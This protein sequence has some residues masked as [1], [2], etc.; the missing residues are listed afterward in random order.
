[1]STVRELKGQIHR[2]NE[3]GGIMTAMKNLAFMELR[4][5]ERHLEAQQILVERIRYCAGLCLSHFPAAGLEGRPPHRLCLILGS[6]RGFCGD[7]NQQLILKG[8]A[9]LPSD[10]ACGLV[11]LGHRLNQRDLGGHE[12]LDQLAGASASEEVEP[13][14]IALVHRLGRLEQLRGPF[15]LTVLFHHPEAGE[16]RLGEVLPPFADLEPDPPAGSPPL[17]GLGLPELMLGIGEQFLMAEL[18]RVLYCSLMAE[19]QQRVVHLQGAI[20][21]LEQHVESL[22]R[23]SNH[24]RQEAIIEEIEIILM[25][26]AE[27]LDP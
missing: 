18:Q 19:N 4:K 9:M 17:L 22:N 10:A 11:T 5:L 6:E 16:V 27:L 24:L 3:I 1:M 13:V 25:N 21:K 2:L 8:Q 26:Q 12:V 14:L 23:R 15:E 7:F 20:Q